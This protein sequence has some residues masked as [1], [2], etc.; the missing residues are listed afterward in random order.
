MLTLPQA[1]KH[2]PPFRSTSGE[3]MGKGFAVLDANGVITGTIVWGGENPPAHCPLEIPEGGS[4]IQLEPEEAERVQEVAKRGEKALFINGQVAIQAKAEQRAAK[5]SAAEKRR[6]KMRA[7]GE[8]SVASRNRVFPELP[9]VP[10]SRKNQAYDGLIA[11]LIR[12]RINENDKILVR[13]LKTGEYDEMT[14]GQILDEVGDMY[15]LQL[16][17]RRH[18]QGYRNQVNKIFNEPALSEEEK[19]AQI[20]ALEVPEFLDVDEKSK[21]KIV[22]KTKSP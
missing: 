17:L 1:F 20:D 15:L 4:S 12:N 8:Q 13:H 21:D 18:D 3:I 14:V 7:I 10:A 11:L 6:E 5:A 19:A 9:H 2:R 16:E 22:R